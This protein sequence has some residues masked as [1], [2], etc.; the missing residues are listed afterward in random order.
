MAASAAI[1]FAQQ[2]GGGGVPGPGTTL[3]AAPG[4]GYVPTSTGAGSTYTAQLPTAGAGGST[5]QG[6]FNG[7]GVL[8]G[9]STFLFNTSTGT[10]SSFKLVNAGA[11]ITGQA[12]LYT[13][14]E[15]NGCDP[16]AEFLAGQGSG[17][18]DTEALTGCV[19]GPTGS[20]TVHQITGVAGYA[21][22]SNSGHPD[23][24]GGYFQG[25]ALVNGAQAF[26]SNSNAVDTSGLTSGVILVG[27]ENDLGALNPTTAYSGGYGQNVVLYNFL[28]TGT[29]PFTGYNV[30]SG[31]A[32][33]Y[34]N[35]G[36]NFAPGSLGASSIG[37]NM[38]AIASATSGSNYNSPV[39]S[40]VYGT[41]WN[42]SSSTNIN[43]RQQLKVPTGTSP[44]YDEWLE[45]ASGI[46]GALHHF[47]LDY[48]NLVDLAFLRSDGSFSTIV[49][50]VATGSNVVF[51]LP[52]QSGVGALSPFSNNIRLSV[53]GASVTIGYDTQ[54]EVYLSSQTSG[55]GYSG[56]GTA[57]VTG[58]TC[59]T[60]PALGAYVIPSGFPNAGGIAFSLSYFGKGCSGTGTVSAAGFA[61]GS[62]ASATLTIYAAVLGNYPSPWPALL[63]S[64]SA[65]SGKVASFNNYAVSGTKVSDALIRYSSNGY[66]TICGSSSYNEYFIVS[67][68][69]AQN[70]MLSTGG[71]LTAAATY[72]QWITLTHALKTAGCK[73]I[74]TTPI[75]RNIVGGASPLPFSFLESINTF[76]QMV[77]SGTVG[78]D[79]DYLIDFA[80]QVNCPADPY[81]YSYDN[82]HF[83]ATGHVVAAQFANNALVAGSGAQQSATLQGANCGWFQNDVYGNGSIYAGT[84]LYATGNLAGLPI[85]SWAGLQYFNNTAYVIA[86]SSNSTPGS[87]VL[88]SENSSG[89]KTAS[90]TLSSTLGTF[91]P[92]ISAPFFESTATQTTVGCSTS[93]SALFSQPEQ[94]ASDKKVLIHMSACNGTAS[95]TYPTAF[96]NTPSIYGS[97]NV[98][99][100]IA[101]SVSTTAVTVTGAT[102]TGS[103]VLEDY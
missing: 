92:P 65:L 35:E 63:E 33:V 58:L 12:N 64:G 36:L 99:A 95:Y 38:N 47:T 73:V 49:P 70:S 97:N 16:Q 90:L 86:T 11:F 17:M 59:T 24:V 89:A 40:S 34:W 62:A 98:A 55:S 53:E 31:N 75:L 4:A 5:T 10:A 51:T 14:S 6:Q 57:T 28:N 76:A 80:S 30:S 77:R 39:F 19:T 2:Q 94:G 43:W 21:T 27:S 101:T 74:V 23:A 91:V 22:S 25:R 56:T 41:A 100:S 102:T 61:G 8:T 15:I 18:Y 1:S 83:T 72:A 85:N 79:Y 45:T 50:T 13:Q 71:N 54:G 7:G 26:G 42:G 37:I 78:V 46:S 68:D 44:T 60:Q 20:P 87:I 48:T 103:L 81:F 32:G 82:T 52:P 88:E 67:G 84:G 3:P 69:L 93:G 9:S 29:F 96:T 66:G